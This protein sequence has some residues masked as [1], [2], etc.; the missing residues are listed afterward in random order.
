MSYKEQT[1]SVDVRWEALTS[2]SPQIPLVTMPVY[3]EGHGKWL[4]AF[5]QQGK[6]V[7]HWFLL[8]FFSNHN[9]EGAL[10]KMTRNDIFSN[11]CW[12]P[13]KQASL[14]YLLEDTTADMLNVNKK[15]VS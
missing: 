10:N 11:M 5:C 3:Q 15:D 12:K 2:H 7:I 8:G 13:R 4:C 6:I 1:A 14:E 9:Q